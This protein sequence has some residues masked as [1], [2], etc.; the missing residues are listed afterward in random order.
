MKSK[1]PLTELT[2]VI[3]FQIL[4]YH[5][6]PVQIEDLYSEAAEII[7]LTEKHFNQ[8]LFHKNFIIF[9]KYADLAVRRLPEKKGL[10]SALR[11]FFAAGC[12]LHINQILHLVED[13]NPRIGIKQIN[14][15]IRSML[16]SGELFV[17]Q[18]KLYGSRLWL[19]PSFSNA[20]EGTNEK[21]PRGPAVTLDDFKDSP[22]DGA[23]RILQ[24]SQKP[25]HTSD[26]IKILIAKGAALNPEN[27]FRLL[28]SDN[29]FD[30]LGSGR[31][32]LDEHLDK[33]WIGGGEDEEDQDNNEA[34]SYDWELVEEEHLQMLQKV[35]YEIKQPISIEKLVTGVFGL[36]PDD[37][38]YQTVLRS[39]N[40]V[41]DS[42]DRFI[43]VSDREWFLIDL[44]PASVFEPVPKNSVKAGSEQDDGN[45]EESPGLKPIPP[46][47]PSAN[48]N[49]SYESQAPERSRIFYL[50]GS[51]LSQGT[52][53]TGNISLFPS[54]PMIVKLSFTD[55]E[56]RSFTGWFNRSTGTVSGL[57]DWFA[58][59]GLAFGDGIAISAADSRKNLYRIFAYKEAPKNQPALQKKRPRVQ[60]HFLRELIETLKNLPEGLEEN[61]LFKRMR[62]DF[63][64]LTEETLQSYLNQFN[65][66][67]YSQ[68]TGKW[69]FKK[70]DEVRKRRRWRK[71][72]FF[73]DDDFEAAADANR[74]SA[75]ISALSRLKDLPEQLASDKSLFPTAL[76]SCLYPSLNE[77]SEGS[78]ISRAQEGDMTARNL[79][80]KAYLSYV[81]NAAVSRIRRINLADNF[82]CW[83][84]FEDAFQ[85][86]ILGLAKAVEKFDGTRANRLYNY[87]HFHVHT[88][89]ERF[90]LKNW[91]EGLKLAVNTYDAANKMNRE[92]WLKKKRGRLNLKRLHKKYASEFRMTAKDTQ[93]LLNYMLDE[94]TGS[95]NLNFIPAD[96][97]VFEI[98]EE[99]ICFETL[100][101]ELKT[102]HENEI[103]VIYMRYG[104]CGDP[105]MTLEEIG[106]KMQLT[107]ERIR[108]IEVKALKKLR[109]KKSIKSLKRCN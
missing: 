13:F 53:Y 48:K 22:I 82:D 54:F 46:K 66:F 99:R 96:L 70:T 21:V 16:N 73:N 7:K 36:P 103:K 8:A 38:N 4:I 5:Q 20:H 95:D 2:A 94:N 24:K 32:M 101:R 58:E 6:K 105:P 45:G 28:Y 18:G 44:L 34:D 63:P 78:L 98:V 56:G 62:V 87:C 79:V 65:Y 92:Y 35:F 91:F 26:L 64:E 12:P 59:R 37:S 19:Q 27:F 71:G 85:E 29:R 43:L 3:I 97:D 90:L 69:F 81:W 57:E 72:N 61:R 42:D 49:L 30:Y 107:R 108:Q 41:L 52:V 80:I 60:R 10:I 33:Y 89:M 88:N 67:V 23:Y 25:I 15:M 51:S 109:A 83:H 50:D 11:D 40:H 74:R 93:K 14:R 9:E 17:I 86:G 31:W 104:L 77:D 55:E 84:L 106:S 68:K 76:I 100:I 39:L 47:T 102:M 75:E 1:N